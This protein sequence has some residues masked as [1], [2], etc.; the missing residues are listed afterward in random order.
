MSR[1]RAMALACS[2]RGILQLGNKI[3]P[4]S[5]ALVGL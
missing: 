5:E 3:P 4:I 1:S 2:N